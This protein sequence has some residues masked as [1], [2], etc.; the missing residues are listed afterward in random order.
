MRRKILQQLEG[1]PKVYPVPLGWLEY[2]H[3]DTQEKLE[4]WYKESVEE[5]RQISHSRTV[6]EIE[7]R[8]ENLRKLA[9]AIL[10]R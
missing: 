10:L 5:V 2:N 9:R 1:P 6:L 3:V 8:S 7:E 4:S